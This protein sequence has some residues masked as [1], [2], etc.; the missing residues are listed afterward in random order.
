[1]A[2]PQAPHDEFEAR[3][4]RSAWGSSQ[5]EPS[6]SRLMVASKP[7]SIYRAKGSRLQAPARAV[8][9]ECKRDAALM[10]RGSLHSASAGSGPVLLVQRRQ[11]SVLV[12]YPLPALSS[13]LLDVTLARQRLLCSTIW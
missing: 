9:S 8:R 7:L 1:M 4:W 3:I 6:S 12:A 13:V 2:H 10:D 5:S 11:K